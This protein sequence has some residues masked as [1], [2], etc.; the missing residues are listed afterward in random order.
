MRT[1][2]IGQTVIFTTI[3]VLLTGCAATKEYTSKLFVPRDEKPKVA[4]LKFLDMDSSLTDQSGWVSTDIITGR[5]T[6]NKSIALDK[7]TRVLPVPGVDTSSASKTTPIES[8]PVAR[9]TNPGEIRTKR[10][11]E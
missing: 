6:I 2:G 7:L 8:E 5:D 3:V 9:Y 11:R 10:T 4:A 1:T